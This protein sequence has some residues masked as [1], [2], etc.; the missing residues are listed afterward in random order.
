MNSLYQP[1]RR[2]VVL[3]TP[4]V[5]PFSLAEAKSQCSIV[6]DAS[7]DTYL[8]GLIEAAASYVADVTS[9]AL[10]ESTWRLL[11]D[12]FPSCDDI[13][14]DWIE[15]PG[16]N[17]RSVTHVKYWVA[18]ELAWTTLAT[19]E[20][21]VDIDSEPGRIVLADGKTWPGAELRRF[22]GIVVEFV[23]GWDA[24]GATKVKSEPPAGIKHAIA[25]LVGHWYK[26]REAVTIGNSASSVSNRLELAVDALVA[27]SKLRYL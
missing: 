8:Q 3:K 21:D 10:T 7:Q 22:N 23:A 26:N 1:T 15:L 16:G 2:Q 19:T 27:N 4:G 18:G 13:N 14:P 17:C 20:Y 11:L 24:P 25:L 12:R 6:D 9:R 5:V